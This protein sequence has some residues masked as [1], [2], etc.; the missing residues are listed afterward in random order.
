MLLARLCLNPALIENIYQQFIPL[1]LI[2]LDKTLETKF[3]NDHLYNA[4]H[5]TDLELQLLISNWSISSSLVITTGFIIDVDNCPWL[6]AG[7][8]NDQ[9]WKESG[10]RLVLVTLTD[11][12]LQT[13]L[14]LQHLKWKQ[15][16]LESEPRMGNLFSKNQQC[17]TVDEQ[18]S[19][20]W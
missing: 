16:K 10:L 2:V 17:E 13:T 14:I 12:S 4:N 8:L 1:L 19:K 9:C 6:R 3:K 20:V 11:T 15:S 7:N 5:S 18:L